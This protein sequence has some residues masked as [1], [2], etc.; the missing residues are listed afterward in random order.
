MSEPPSLSHVPLVTYFQSPGSLSVP[1]WP[2]HEW[3]PVALA[4]S[5][6]PALATPK[7][8]SLLWSGATGPAWA[9][10]TAPTVSMDARAAWRTRRVFMNDCSIEGVSADRVAFH[11]ALTVRRSGQP[12]LTGSTNRHDR[13]LA[14]RLAIA[15]L[16][17]MSEALR[18]P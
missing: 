6:A 7:H 2:A 8:L 18:I 10:D 15:P 17:K 11:A 14:L 16:A 5:L 9:N 13:E 4:Q 12:F 1:A 3:L